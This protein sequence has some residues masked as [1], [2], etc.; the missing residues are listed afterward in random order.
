MK[1]TFAEI[2]AVGG[3]TNSLGRTDEVIQ[4]VLNDKSKLEELYACTFNNDAWVRMR[5]MDAIE[6]IC[7]EHPEWILPYIDRFQSELAP[8]EQPSIQWHLAQIYQQVEL[9]PLQK[10][11]AITWLKGL[12]SNKDVD[13]IVSANAMGTLMQFFK[14]GSISKDE[15]AA[16]IKVQQK[17]KSKAVVKK[18]DKYLQALQN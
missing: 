1:E 10:K 8:S 7:R 15:V 17:H 9:M 18:M 14:D 12:L 16:L 2:L 4:T 6:K 13:W 3:K 5:A 11:R